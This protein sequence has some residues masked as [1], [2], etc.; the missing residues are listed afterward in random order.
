MEVDQRSRHHEMLR[1]IDFSHGRQHVFL[2]C[3]VLA[4][5]LALFQ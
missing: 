1:L 5:K 3:A 2:G 4:S